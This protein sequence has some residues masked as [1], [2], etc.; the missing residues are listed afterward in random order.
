M[1]SLLPFSPTSLQANPTKK[2]IHVISD[3]IPAHKT[4][5][6][7]TF[8]VDDPQVHMQIA[9]T[10]SSWLN[11]LSYGLPRSSAMCLLAVISLG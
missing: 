5:R 7:K 11:Q 1:R 3:N 9:P 8:L 2:E 4:D 10:Y 6:V